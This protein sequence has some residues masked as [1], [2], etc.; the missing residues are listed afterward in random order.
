LLPQA[1]AGYISWEEYEE[2]QRRLLECAQAHGQDRRASP[3]R[4]GPALLQGLVVCGKCGRRMTV[5]YH[6]RRGRL[7]PEY[8]C[9]HEGIEHGQPKCQTMQ[10]PGIDDAVGKM[11]VETVTPTALDL[12]LAIQQ[13]LQ[14][15]LDE[16]DRLRKNQIER[17]QYEADLAQ[18]RYMQVDPGN[19][20]VAASLE[21]EW[22]ERLRLLHEAQQ[23]YERRRQTEPLMIDSAQR[24]QVLA[25]ATDFPALWNDSRTS[26]RD[27]KRMVR[28]LIDDVTLVKGGEL[29]VQVRFKGGATRTLALP[30]PKNAWEERQTDPAVIAEIDHLLD[31]HTTG[32]IA[33]ILNQEG[34]NSGMGAGFTRQS[35]SRLQREHGLKSRFDRLREQGLLTKTEMAEKLGVTDCTIKVWR[36]HGLLRAQAYTDRSEY[37]YEP[38]GADAPAKSQGWKLSERRIQAALTSERTQEV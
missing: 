4:E 2:N 36:K 15:R 26:Y 20:L 30:L 18:R 29:T 34:R 3:P 17:A 35:V 16:A 23:E 25:L 12:T 38:P 9:Q 37:L 14:G 13:E 11:L 32:R 31:Q 1:H 33:K 19:R 8:L 24:K 21:A 10:G 6:F 27:R 7:A 5:R 22:N 28:L